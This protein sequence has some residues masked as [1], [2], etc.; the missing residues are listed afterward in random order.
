MVVALAVAACAGHEPRAP[1]AQAPI[2]SACTE[3][4]NRTGSALGLV[5]QT[6]FSGDGAARVLVTNAGHQAR[7]VTPELVAI[8]R[9]PCDGGW[10]RC[11]RHRG[12]SAA[13]RAH[14]DVALG[15]GESIELLVDARASRE[16][17]RCEK[18]GLFLVTQVDGKRA[19]NDAGVWLAVPPS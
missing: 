13:E 4:A 11:Q 10:T 1:S 17:T 16:P 7:R 15:S 14:Y 19:C 2:E 12:F 6:E 8:C 5:T 9:G 18:I 3:Y